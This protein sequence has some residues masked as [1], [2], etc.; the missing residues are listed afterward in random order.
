MLTKEGEIIVAY[1]GTKVATV[2]YHIECTEYPSSDCI[3][4]GRVLRATL[5]ED[6]EDG[7]IVCSYDGRWIVPPIEYS[8]ADFVMRGIL[9]K[10]DKRIDGP[11][12]ASWC[13][14]E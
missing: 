7:N 10:Y 1:S 14:P 3:D 4:G 8:D 12:P 5:R 2:H 11:L 9:K 6:G 13:V